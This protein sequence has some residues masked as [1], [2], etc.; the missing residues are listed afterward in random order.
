MSDI[1][2]HHNY[3]AK[4]NR[5]TVRTYVNESKGSMQTEVNKLEDKYFGNGLKQNPAQLGQFPYYYYSLGHLNKER[6]LKQEMRSQYNLMQDQPDGYVYGAYEKLLRET[7]VFKV[8]LK[9]TNSLLRTKL[10]NDLNRHQEIRLPKDNLFIESTVKLNYRKYDC[11]IFGFHVL[12]SPLTDLSKIRNP[13][14]FQR[15]IETSTFDGEKFTDVNQLFDFIDKCGNLRA[16]KVVHIE[17][18]PSQYIHTVQNVHILWKPEHNVVDRLKGP[19]KVLR[20]F[21]FN[22]VLFVNNPEVDFI[23]RET[24]VKANK[25]RLAQGRIPKPNYAVIKLK[26]QLKKVVNQT[27]SFPSGQKNKAHEVRGHW[28]NFYNDKYTN[29]KGKRRW[30]YPFVRGEGIPVLRNYEHLSRR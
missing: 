11:N 20:D 9:I 24:P 16:F 22:Y 10:P 30:I 2:N 23:Y 4:D 26:G 13:N 17:T 19:E 3:H 27:P 12:D 5:G 14:L 28:R 1:W 15:I 25:K 21:I 18:H 6:Q 29:M 8:P 7:T